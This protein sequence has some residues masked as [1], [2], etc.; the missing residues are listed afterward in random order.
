MPSQRDFGIRLG[1]GVN[2]VR[3]FAADCAVVVIVDVLC[4]STTVEVA[5]SRG[6]TILPHRMGDDSAAGYAAERDASLAVGRGEETPDRPF[7]LSPVSM[8]A[9]G[10]GDR[11]VLPSPNGATLCIAARSREDGSVARQCRR[12]DGR[13]RDGSSGQSGVAYPYENDS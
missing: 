2:A 12:G 11:V 3:G 9:A 4:F 1:W 10:Q 13:S 5:V 8:E 6:A 7:S